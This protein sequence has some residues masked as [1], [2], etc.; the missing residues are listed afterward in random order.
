MSG[1]DISLAQPGTPTYA[2]FATKAW[3]AEGIRLQKLMNESKS[4][5]R[6]ENAGLDPPDL[7]LSDN[8]GDNSGGGF[9]TGGHNNTE[10]HGKNPGDDSEEQHHD[11]EHGDAQDDGTCKEHEKAN[12]DAQHVHRL[13]QCGHKAIIHQPRG[14]AAHIDFIVNDQ[15]ECYMGLDSVPFGRSIDSTWPSK[16]KC[17]DVEEPCFKTCGKNNLDALNAVERGGPEPKILKLSDI[18]LED[19][20]WNLD[21]GDSVD[22]GV[23]GLFKLGGDGSV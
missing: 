20:E 22:G 9:K 3:Q 18:N 15:V 11:H 14:G 1:F 10:A 21:G 2:A 16:Y 19:P 6:R 8:E 13:G 17:K 12:C 23:M 4:S 5:A 7:D